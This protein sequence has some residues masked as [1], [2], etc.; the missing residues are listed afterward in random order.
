MQSCKNGSQSDRVEQA[1]QWIS[2]IIDLSDKDALDIL[3][4]RAVEQKVFDL[5]DEP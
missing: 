1:R 5:V 2:K 4:F 3:R